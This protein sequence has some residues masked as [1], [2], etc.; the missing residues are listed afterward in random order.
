MRK[1]TFTV[2][3]TEHPKQGEKLLAALDGKGLEKLPY[4]R[5]ALSGKM[6]VSFTIEPVEG[7]FESDV[8][9]FAQ[10]IAQFP[11]SDNPLFDKAKE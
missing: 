5:D 11:D 10:I 8:N 9:L 6:T 7:S 1:V 3:Y 4:R 2:G